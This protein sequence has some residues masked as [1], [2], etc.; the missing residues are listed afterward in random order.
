M[1]NTTIGTGW[2]AA[3]FLLANV[4]SGLWLWL[5]YVPEPALAY[6]SIVDLENVLYAGAFIRSIHYFSS[7]FFIAALLAHAAGSILGGTDFSTL[8]PGRWPSGVVLA[9]GLVT[10]AFL[11]KALPCDQHGGVSLVVVKNFAGLGSGPTL[12]S[13]LWLHIAG[14]LILLPLMAVHVGP[15]FRGR[16]ADAGP[17]CRAARVFFGVVGALTVIVVPLAAG[18]PLGPAYDERL[19]SAGVVAQWHLRWLQWLTEASPTAARIALPALLLLALLTPRLRAAAGDRGMRIAWLA[20]AAV[21][22][23]MSFLRIG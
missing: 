15:A 20:V 13:I 21:L 10:L 7:H 18:A 23:I 5:H 22:V 17:G 3:V 2:L 9:A 19:S 1:K 4:L 16:P 11:G 6:D 12:T 14:T 8:A